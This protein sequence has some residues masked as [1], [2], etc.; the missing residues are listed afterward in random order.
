MSRA[1][2]A[3]RAADNPRKSVLLA[4][5]RAVPCAVAE[6][7]A[8]QSHCVAAYEAHVGA[9]DLVTEAKAGIATAPAA[10]VAATLSRAETGLE[11]ARHLTD[12]CATRQGE[13]VRRYRVAR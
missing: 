8:V 1:I 5:L 4:V 7:C 6:V 11:R 2:D 3:V 13:L 10:S 9:L 12:E